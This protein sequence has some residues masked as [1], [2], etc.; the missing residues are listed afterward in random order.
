MILFGSFSKVHG[1]VD[2]SAYP[3]SLI[4]AKA[5]VMGCSTALLSLSLNYVEHLM[6]LWSFIFLCR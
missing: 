5:H 1:V 4:D 2:A 3:L 6:K